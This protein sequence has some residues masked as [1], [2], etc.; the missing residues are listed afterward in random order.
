MN[1]E[2]EINVDEIVRVLLDVRTAKPG[3]LIKL[4]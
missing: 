1:Q 4:P 3:K 2:V